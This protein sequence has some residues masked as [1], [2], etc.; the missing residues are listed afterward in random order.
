[1]ISDDMYLNNH[2]VISDTTPFINLLSFLK[3]HIGFINDLEFCFIVLLLPLFASDETKGDVNMTEGI[4][5]C[6]L[7]KCS[8]DTVFSKFIIF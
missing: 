5:F 4:S 1:M 8:T 6:N 3:L 7:I 2:G